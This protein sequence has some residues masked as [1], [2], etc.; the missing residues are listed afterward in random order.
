MYGVCQLPNGKR[1]EGLRSAVEN[2]ANVYAD[3]ALP[4]EAKAAIAYGILQ[5]A[6]KF[7]GR[8]LTVE[9]GMIAAICKVNDATLATH[10]T[11]DFEHLDIKLVDP[12]TAKTP[13]TKE[14]SDCV[15]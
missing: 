2:L 4:Y 14:P 10:N 11:K 15:L 6:S 5:G 13:S 9:D 1:R 12:F 7:A 3:R 8:T